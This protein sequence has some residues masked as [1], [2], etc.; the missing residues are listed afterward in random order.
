MRAAGPPWRTLTSATAA[1]SVMAGSA[2][3]SIL[4]SGEQNLSFT[5]R[6]R[7]L[8]TCSEQEYGS[9]RF[10]LDGDGQQDFRAAISM[11]FSEGRMAARLHGLIQNDPPVAGRVASRSPAGRALAVAFASGSSI[12]ASVDASFSIISAW[13]WQGPGCGTAGSWDGTFAEEIAGVE[14]GGHYGWI[15]IQLS[16]DTCAEFAANVV[17][18]AYETVPG[19]PIQAGSIPEPTVSLLTGLALLALGVRGLREQRSRL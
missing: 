19:K 14:L 11:M 4:Y 6:D 18:W 3:A 15:R 12:G 8:S 1:A 5:G 13:L 2:D 17:D 7:C 10:D 16:H 9:A